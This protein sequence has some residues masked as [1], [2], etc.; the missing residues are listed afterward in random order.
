MLIFETIKKIGVFDLNKS[1]FM[2]NYSNKIK[3]YD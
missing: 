1:L 3:S 2:N